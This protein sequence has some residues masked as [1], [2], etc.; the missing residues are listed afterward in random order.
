MSAKVSLNGWPVI[1]PVIKRI[2]ENPNNVINRYVHVAYNMYFCF[3]RGCNGSGMILLDSKSYL[4]KC[5]RQI[6]QVV[7]S[8]RTKSFQHDLQMYA[9]HSSFPQYV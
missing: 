6:G 4:F 3:E 8:F 1:S 9:L 7:V 5:C 2:D